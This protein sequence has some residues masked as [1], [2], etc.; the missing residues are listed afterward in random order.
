VTV[1]HR[2]AT[3][4][5]LLWMSA[6]S[7]QNLSPEDT[8]L[9]EL[10]LTT[11]LALDKLIHLL[12]VRSDN[13]ELMNLRLSWEEGRLLAW[14]DRDSLLND[15][16]A[17]IKARARWSPSAYE[18]LASNLSLPLPPTSPSHTPARASKTHASP[19]PAA[20]SRSTRYKI[21]E[22]LT[23]EAAGFGSRISHFKKDT[24]GAPGRTVDK[25]IDTSRQPVPDAMLDEQEK[26]EN[27]CNVMDGLGK[28][29][30]NVMVQWK[31]CEL[32]IP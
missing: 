1:P 19:T 25:I 20:F 10:T 27:G 18:T 17:F 21:S 11:L 32:F 6:K 3:D 23:R 28:F 29:A 9:I 13:L 16:E 7:K 14:K 8:D 24:V 12:R 30:M 4:S 22:L 2:V 5:D 15:L 26:L 31:K